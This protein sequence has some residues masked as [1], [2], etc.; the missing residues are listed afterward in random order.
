MQHPERFALSRRRLLGAG[1]AGGTLALAGC[2]GSRV[3]KPTPGRVVVVGGGYG[4]AT[5]ARYLR[6]WGG[7]EVTLVEREA[8]FVSCPISNLVLGGWRTLADITRGYDG[9][10]AAGVK[11]VRGEAVA[12]DTERR[13]LHLADGSTLPWDRLIVAPGIDF[14]TAGI[15][16]LQPALDAGTV[17][18]A[19]KAGPQT[20]ALRRQLEALPDGG[21]VAI[22][23]PRA[24]FRCPPGPYERAAVI[25]SWLKQARPRAKLLLLDANTEIQSKKALFQRAFGEHLK[26]IVEYRPDAELREVHGR[27]ARFDFEDVKAD[28]L[29]VIPPQRAGR[30]AQDAGLV[31]VNG[32]WVGVDWLTLESQ[33][34]PGV[35]VLGDA[36]FSAPLMPKSGHMANQHAK[37]VAAAVIQRLRGEPVNPAPLVMNTCYSYLSATHAVHVASVHPYDAAEK[38]FK[39]VPASV[40]VS[41]D[42]NT[43]EALYAQAWAENIWADAL[44]L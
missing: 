35:H 29:N 2:A 12:I 34:L 9:L 36:T 20:L 26:G 17:T 1:L 33:A 21:V 31:T 10:A 38:T 28:V 27:L 32:R 14:D 24:P 41:R 3:A 4:G 37:V 22:T 30:L 8:A 5:A 42:W 18:H 13:L 44:A 6:L 16:G 23:I 19:W 40:G 39:A 25:G 43:A 7:V 11:L 15:P